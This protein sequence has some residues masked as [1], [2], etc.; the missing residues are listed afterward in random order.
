MTLSGDNLRLLNGKKIQVRNAA[1]SN[2][3]DILALNGNNQI[4]M[5]SQIRTKLF[6]F[7]RAVRPI[8]VKS[9]GAGA[10]TGTAGDINLIAWPSLQWEYAIKGTQTIVAPDMTTVGLDIGSMDQTADD[11]IEL[12]PGQVSTHDWSFTIGTSPAF[13]FSMK[14]KLGTVAATDDCAIG[15]RKQAA[16]T[17]N[18]DDYTDFAVLNVIT[19]DIKIETALNN[20]A[21]TTTDTTQNWADAETHTLAVYVSSAGVVTYKIDGSAPT[22][23]AAFTFDTG[24]IVVPFMF[25]LQHTGLTTAPLIEMECDYQ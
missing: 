13:Y 24:D 2:W 4:R 1:D 3:I 15:F 11:G 17:A 5:A 21:T 25:F 6:S 14:F 10:A 23:T 22:T 19:G 7:A 12:S 16:Y 8:C 20:A 18:I 9:I